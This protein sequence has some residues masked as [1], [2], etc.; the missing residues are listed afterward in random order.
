MVCL[1]VGLFHHDNAS[2]LNDS[3]HSYIGTTYQRGGA[4]RGG[5]SVA[6]S[7]AG[8]SVY[9]GSAH[10]SVDG[11]HKQKQKQALT[12]LNDENDSAV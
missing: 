9:G 6:G 4:V 3:V 8:G 7:V 1:C 5:G 10:G 12:A 11:D 2:E